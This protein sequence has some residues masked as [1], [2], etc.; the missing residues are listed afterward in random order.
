MS[1]NLPDSSGAQGCG[2]NTEGGT[3][4]GGYARYCF[5]THTIIDRQDGKMVFYG[6]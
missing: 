3:A 6:E 2:W 5:G 1:P 4:G